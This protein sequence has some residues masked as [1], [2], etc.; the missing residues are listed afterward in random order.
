MST[1]K[2]ACILCSRNCGLEVETTERHFVRI[3]GDED[4]PV[5][6]GYMCQKGARLGFY[7]DNADRLTHPLRRMPD[8]SYER[9][10]WE[11]ALGDI[12]ARLLKIRASHGGRA[13]AFYGGGGQGNHLG[14]AYGRQ[15]QKAMK[16][17]YLYNSL[18]QE[19]TGDFW[20]NGRLFGKQTCHT[21]EDVEHADFVLVIGAN[22]WQAHGIP[23][24]RDTLRDIKQ[25]PKR[26]LV[27][28]DP[29]RTET[30][31]DAD[32]HLQ[33]RPG[34][35]AFLMAAMLG[36]IV[37]EGL[38]DRAF[39]AQHTTGFPA[40]ERVLRAVPVEDYVARADVPLADVQ[41]VARGFAQAESACVRVDLGIQQSPRTTLNG[42]LEKL[43][44][45]VTGNFG[46]R[47]GN[48]LHTF[49]LPVIGHTD[50]RSP[51]YWRT[52]NQGMHAIS[53]IYPPNILPAEIEH[54]G[55]D[56]VRALFVDS[57][58][59]AVTAADSQ[60]YARAL[61]KLELLV[62]VDVAF[63]ET[64]RLADYVLPAASQFEK[65]ECTG[66][67]LE[68]PVNA[69]Q[70]RK[71]LFEPLGESL[72]EAEIYTRLLEAMGELPKR[73]PLL[74]R[75]ARSEPEQAQHLAFLGA[76]GATLVTRPKWQPYAASVLYRTLG[77]ALPEGAA[78]TAFLL[79]LAIMY[80]GKHARAVRRAGYTG[81]RAT[82][83][84]SLFRAI[85]KQRS[86]VVLSRHEYGEVWSLLAHEDQR[87]HLDVP[88]ML[89][90][91]GELAREVPPNTA[92]AEFPF[93]LLA[94][95]RRMY[96]ANAIFRDPAW[97][98]QDKE[99]ALRIH[100]ADADALGLAEGKRAR[101]RSARGAI[102][103]S[104]KRDESVRR[105]MVT[106]PHGH[107]TRYGDSEPI[108][109]ALNQLTSAEHCEPFTRTPFHKHVPV[110]LEALPG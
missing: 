55:D 22:P 76:L 80:A 106:L 27:V 100:P 63:T 66:F 95:E 99:G 97:R 47:G 56:R 32:V 78:S 37:Q 34:T 88:E 45:L 73:F 83:G 60:A 1:E 84:V 14:G 96:N 33:L 21:T 4:H 79:P 43:L 57:A 103:V 30:A 44:F 110:Q 101:V 67:N 105:G 81:N 74:E 89:S 8:G 82:L 53:G 36:I 11:Q 93:V 29:R 6:K 49:L 41:R 12:A 107:G 108:G 64:A 2:T 50:E 86:G 38:H 40:L 102:E 7:Q 98:K 19:K 72:P 87:A 24:A 90:A 52:A 16:S 18:A 71:P 5:S 109:P 92:N 77:K 59:P 28:I 46:K 9:T 58:N 69:F 70:L 48:N 51:K 15:L 61:G 31:K 62:V 91:L 20:A 39:L 42:Y 10:T 85:L 65:W 104:V 23:N 13:F 35:D 17:R 3:R 54:P 25:D 68:F 26:T 75:I 94:G